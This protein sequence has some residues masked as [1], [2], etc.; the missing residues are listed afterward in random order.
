[1]RDVDRFKRIGLEVV[2][3][4]FTG[5]IARGVPILSKLPA[6]LA[7]RDDVLRR[8]DV[9]PA[10]LARLPIVVGEDDLALDRLALRVEH[11]RRV[12]DAFPRCLRSA[13]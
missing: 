8:W 2:H 11:D 4:E 7:E 5:H 1:M 6:L 3:L 9:R 10:G 12:V 13:R